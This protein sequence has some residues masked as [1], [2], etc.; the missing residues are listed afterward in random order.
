MRLLLLALALPS[1]A[2]WQ[3]V[4]PSAAAAKVDF[5]RAAN[6][7]VEF[8]GTGQLVLTE[9]Q[10]TDMAIRAKV[11]KLGGNNLSLTVRHTD[12]G[13]YAAWFNGRRV[14][15]GRNVGGR[16]QDIQSANL[17]GAA[18]DFFDFEL[19]V[20]G[21]N[22]AV[23]VNGDTLI[24][25]VNDTHRQGGAGIGSI[26]GPA[27]F[28]D[29]QVSQGQTIPAKPPPVASPPQPRPPRTTA[30]K[31]SGFVS[32]FNGRDLSGRRPNALVCFVSRTANSSPT[33]VA[34]ATRAA[35]SF[36]MA[37]SSSGISNCA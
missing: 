6:G 32:I 34:A 35:C 14:G 33:A 20:K 26:G 24:Q 30:T 8:T 18:T 13:F 16:W 3:P 15:L 29:I 22:L 25:A 37:T 1:F 21:Q 11:R 9:G 7:I 10:T 4:D 31:E 5:A 28:K 36:M 17:P 19:R 12:A 2:A 27:H 23:V